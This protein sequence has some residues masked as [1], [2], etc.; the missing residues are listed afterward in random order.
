MTLIEKMVRDFS[1]VN[2]TPKS[3]IR[4]R[5]NELLLKQRQEWITK[6]ENMLDD[7]RPLGD[8]IKEELK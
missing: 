1:Q 8:L 3:E 4:R 7:G 5:I 2:P 6:L